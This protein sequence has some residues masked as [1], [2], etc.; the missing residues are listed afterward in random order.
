[1]GVKPTGRKSTGRQTN[2]ATTNW[3]TRVGQLGDSVSIFLSH[4]LCLLLYRLTINIKPKS[5]ARDNVS[6]MWI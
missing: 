2:W 3:K 1:M 4:C 5:T 6:E